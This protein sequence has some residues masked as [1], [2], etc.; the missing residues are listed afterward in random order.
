[1]VWI[2][3]TLYSCGYGRG[4]HVPKQKWIWLFPTFS[5]LTIHQL[6]SDRH[7]ESVIIFF[8]S[9]S[10]IRKSGWFNIQYMFYTAVFVDYWFFYWAYLLS[11]YNQ[12][13][14]TFTHQRQQSPVFLATDCFVSR[15]PEE[16]A[17]WMTGSCS[18]SRQSCPRMCCCDSRRV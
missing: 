1:M 11:V 18:D 17:D 12:Y 5:M 9:L 2:Q 16:Q 13:R 15:V 14:C 6:F 7:K 10:F 3:K 4:L 8:P